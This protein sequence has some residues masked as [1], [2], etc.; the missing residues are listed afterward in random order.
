[1]PIGTES[2]AVIDHRLISAVG[3]EPLQP[4][5]PIPPGVTDLT[6]AFRE[7]FI[8]VD[9]I[10][11][12]LADRPVEAS[13]RALQLQAN[14][15]KSRRMAEQ[16]QLAPDTF[17]L[18]QQDIQ[19]RKEL[20]PGELALARHKQKIDERRMEALEK[21]FNADEDIRP[22]LEAYKK[23]KVQHELDLV[24]PDDTI[25]AKAQ[26]RDANYRLEDAY[27]AAFGDSPDFVELNSQAKPQDFEKWAARTK[28]K[29]VDDAETALVQQY[30]QATPDSIFA[31]R[32]RA[33]EAFDKDAASLYDSYKTELRQK[34]GVAY[35]GTPAYYKELN[36]RITER[37][38]EQATQGAQ[39]KAYE[40]GLVEG[41]KTAA[42]APAKSAET[43]TKLRNEIEQSKQIQNFRLQNNA[44]DLVK[45][46]A[47]IPNP[48]NRS[49]LQLIY[50][51]VKLADP[52]SVVREGEIA[53]SRQADPVLVSMKK[54]LE[55]LTSTNG[56]LLNAADRTEL[57]R[58]ADTVIAQA[59]NNIRP[60]FEKFQ[61]LAVQQGIPPQ[62]IF[63]PAEA[64]FVGGAQPAATNA[65]DPYAAM[66][67][68]TVRT[69]D[70][71]VGVVI[72]KPDGTYTIK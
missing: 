55:G 10:Q 28:K 62:D 5:A 38:Q 9:D 53:L 32:H 44:A 64:E 18:Q 41:A 11:K 6:K 37:G 36:R 71:R 57:A 66:V 31:E 56:K 21:D 17:A 49:D 3:N 15:F 8:T 61:R 30:P 43:A 1:M 24:S 52:G 7:G 14:D 22:A 46:F 25:R 23:Q 29:Y 65:A 63:S 47:T 39:F 19:A 50:A 4:L 26:T 54:R 34:N 70:G 58:I 40:A 51:A 48:S 45:T 67:G 42:G 2:G 20:A 35:R 69:K 59:R 12:R 13:N 60:E 27:L 33:E 72:R 16:E 68:K